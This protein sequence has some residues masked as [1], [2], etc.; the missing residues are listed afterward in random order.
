[1]VFIFFHT[2]F[3]VCIVILVFIFA[4]EF[5]SIFLKKENVMY[6]NYSI[7]TLCETHTL[8]ILKFLSWSQDFSSPVVLHAFELEMTWLDPG[9]ITELSNACKSYSFRQISI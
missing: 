3:Y 8:C 4:T 5:F 7:Y 1:M 2:A 6:I 9:P